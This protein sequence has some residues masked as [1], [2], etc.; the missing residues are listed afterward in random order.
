MQYLKEFSQN[1]IDPTIVSAIL[2]KVY[3]EENFKV[4][5]NKALETAATRYDE[6]EEMHIV[7]IGTKHENLLGLEDDLSRKKYVQALFFHEI[8][9]T[10]FTEKDLKDLSRICQEIK[11]PFSLLNLA[12]DARIE[13]LVKKTIHNAVE[14]LYQFGWQEWLKNPEEVADMSPENILFMMINTENSVPIAAIKAK[15]VA[16][17][18]ERFLAANNTYE[19]LSILKEWKETFHNNNDQSMKNAM[20][21]LAEQME[22]SFG[23][24][25]PGGAGDKEGTESKPKKGGGAEPASDDGKKPESISDSLRQK[26]ISDMSNMLEMQI[27]AQAAKDMD[28]C[29]VPHEDLMAEHETVDPYRIK[30][31]FDS[32]KIEDASNTD[33]IFNPSNGIGNFYE[34]DVKEIETMLK[35]LEKEKR[36]Q[37]PTRNVSRRFNGR[38][39]AMA[40]TSFNSTKIYKEDVSK[41]NSIG[42]E[43]IMV[44][45]LSGSMSGKPADSQRTILLAANTMADKFKNFNMTI[46]GSKVNGRK[47]LYQSFS[48]PVSEDIL[49]GCKA[50]GSS[51][52]IA[53][54][55]DKNSSLFKKQ[56]VAIFITDGNVHDGEIAYDGIKK[57][58]KQGAI[59]VGV[60]VGPSNIAN[61]AMKN[62]FD[63]LI[64]GDDLLLAVEELISVIEKGASVL[65]SRA[66]NSEFVIE[67]EVDQE[68]G[69]ATRR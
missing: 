9:H 58:M 39:L 16:E 17:F 21:A 31:H 19:V 1:F 66:A 48:L 13:Y 27:N 67:A 68:T 43:I 56:D 62:W 3:P 41:K 28:A 54:A 46:I 59:S 32:V 20:E 35:R 69:M 34:N 49:L 55:I 44:L 10:L 23:E 2:M 47:S 61:A 24:P 33:S 52:G 4:M 5:I 51:E 15:K 7:Y 26:N 57:H 36:K 12:E 18:Y 45:D 25:S 53:Y 6:K 8:G 38:T 22:Q 63:V 42:K 64:V 37:T 14:V 40:T 30:T 60:Y 65:R 11:I 29:S 50:N